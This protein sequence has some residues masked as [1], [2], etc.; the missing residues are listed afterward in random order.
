MRT[1]VATRVELNGSGV[2]REAA[3]RFYYTTTSEEGHRIRK[4]GFAN[5]HL[6]IVG[7]KGV[8]V[9]TRPP[10]WKPA[11]FVVLA[12]D[13]PADQLDAQWKIADDPVGTS[14]GRD[15]WLLPAADATRHL[16]Q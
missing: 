9:G 4:D 16:T 6:A 14:S 15:E 5:R 12:I 8:H 3:M 11:S 1:R 7:R 13:I 10:L 2:E